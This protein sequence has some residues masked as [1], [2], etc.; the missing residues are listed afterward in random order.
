ME[1]HPVLSLSEITA[2]ERAYELGAPTL[3]LAAAHLL[4]RW[5]H[6]LRDEETFLRLLFLRWFRDY[7][8][9]DM[10]GLIGQDIPA[11]EDLIEQYGGLDA[12]GPEA[13][14]VI[15]HLATVAPDALGRTNPWH[16]QAEP[17]FRAAE[18]RFPAS[19]LFRCWPYF[20]GTTEDLQSPRQELNLEIHARFHG[21]GA[22]GVYLE[23]VLNV[24][25]PRRRPAPTTDDTPAP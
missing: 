24:P 17:L 20:L 4:R 6:H 16:A 3:G 22:L 25:H 21:R 10:T 13:S 7:E 1:L 5:V 15:A 8:P 12:A 14:F 2:I 9:N 19:Y 18:A 23:Q 11:P